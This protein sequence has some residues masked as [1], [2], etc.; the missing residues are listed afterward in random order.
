MNQE[1]LNREFET[2]QAQL[3]SFVLRMTCSVQDS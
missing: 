3:K 2:F 1:I